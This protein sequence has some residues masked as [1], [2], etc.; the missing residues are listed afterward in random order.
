MNKTRHVGIQI[1]DELFRTLDNIAK[2]QGTSISEVIRNF[3]F[4]GLND[5]VTKENMDFISRVIR[6]Q[7]DLVIAPYINRLTGQMNKAGVMAATAAFLNSETI[8]NLVP[9]DRRKKAQ[10]VYIQ[11]RKQG[12]NYMKDPTYTEV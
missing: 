12:V 8:Q 10:D 4:Q 2:K 5:E 9:P 6:E 1:T 11:A 3:I 7:L